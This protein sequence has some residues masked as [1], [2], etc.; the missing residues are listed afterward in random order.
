VFGLTFAAGTIPGANAADDPAAD[1]TVTAEA[2]LGRNVRAGDWV[3]VRVRLENAGPTVDGELRIAS[4]EQGASTYGVVVQLAPGARQDHVLYGKAG[5]FGSRLRVTLVSAGS[6]VATADAPVEAGPVKVLGVYIVAERPEQLIGDLR[7]SVGS[8]GGPSPEVVAIGPEDLPPRVE[9]WAG[10]DRLVWQDVPSANLAGEQLDALRTWVASGGDLVI[11]G[12]STGTAA[13]QGFPDDLLPYRPERVID[14]PVTDLGDLLGNEPVGGTSLPALAGELQRGTALARSADD[15][16]AARATYGSGS[17]TLIGI[18]PATS[19]LVGSAAAARLW[20]GTVPSSVPRADA[21]IQDDSFLLDALTNLPSVDLPR[22][23][24]LFLLFAGYVLLLG[25]VNYFVLRRLDRREWAWFTMPALALAFTLAAFMLGVLLRGT[26]VV[27]NELAIVRGAAGTDR[28]IADAYVGIFSPS[29]ATFDVRLAG[30]ALIS[31]PVIDQQDPGER[32]LDILFGDPARLRGFSVGFGELRGFRAESAVTTPRVDAD[33]ELVEDRL[34]G[35]VTNASDAPLD[36]VS[37]VYGDR[38][39][40]VGEMGPGETAS[41]DLRPA[42]GG[43]SRFSLAVQLLGRSDTDDAAAAR[44]L[45]SRSAIIR[46]LVGGWEV[47]PRPSDTTLLEGAPVIL[48]W[49]SGGVLDIDLG[50]AADRMGDT[51]YVLPVLAT[52]SGP[53]TY[54]GGALAHSVVEIDAVEGS[55]GRSGDHLHLDRG[56]MTLAYRPVG[57][58][59]VFQATELSVRLGWDHEAPSVDATD[60]APLPATEQ[61]DDDDPIGPGPTDG[62]DVAGREPLPRVQLFDRLDGGWVEFEPLAPSET[63]RI[64]DP[65]RYVDASG[66]FLVRFVNLEPEPASGFSLEARLAGTAQ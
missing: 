19:W 36:H 3:A 49:R 61:P 17:V 55:G 48:A 45:A 44:T 16:V 43:V 64:A 9:A 31:E 62:P 24:Q 39:E 34:V 35:T 47:G 13:L 15:T 21:G 46:H 41:V 51:L 8:R 37:V 32:P 7:E 18:D 42:D 54:S 65:E 5:F 1:V 22:M 4:D 25:P 40:I 57:F 60:L 6:V 20:G 30:G 29:R 52:A 58:E 23:D 11:V 56:T 66:T 53:V 26:S 28:G 10:I 63:Y 2:M 12:G 59:G 50:V 38:L 14:V 27:I 33:L